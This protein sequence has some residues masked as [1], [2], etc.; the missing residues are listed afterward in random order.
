MIPS[1]NIDHSVVALRLSDSLNYA[2]DLLDE[3]KLFHLPVV[4]ENE[5]LGYLSEEMILNSK[6]DLIGDLVL[7]GEKV[8]TNDQESIYSSLRKLSSNQVSCLAVLGEEN[9]YLGVIT[10]HSVFKALAEISAIRSQGAVIS[11]VIPQ[12]D[13]SLSELSRILEANG[14]K[15]LSVELVTVPESPLML[16][17]IFKLNT[18]DITLACATMERYG[19]TVNLRFGKNNFDTDNSNR[20]N[21]ILNY[22]NF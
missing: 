21:E 3:H 9:E 6:G 11:I 18:F 16:E 5:Y 2:L 19:Y 20:L 13:Y 1:L 17:V 15:V 10:T 22:L 8:Y 4:E 12:H 14:Y 7:S